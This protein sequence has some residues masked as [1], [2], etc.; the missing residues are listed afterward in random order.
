MSKNHHEA[1]QHPVFHKV[2]QNLYRLESSGGY[3]ALFKRS[4]K[5]I[6]RS[7]KTTDPALARRRLGELHDKVS[8]LNQTKGAS[9]IT[10][11]QLGDRWLANIRVN[12]KESSAERLE[13]CLKGLEP[14]LGHVAVRNVT[15][16]HCEAWM[17][18]RGKQISAS[19]Y[20]HER[21]TLIAVL[22]YAVR[23]GLILN[24]PA[25][26]AVPTR[27]IPKPK[28]TIPTQEQFRLLVTT[29]RQA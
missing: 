19:S 11:K 28:I 26:V 18:K 8:R 23:D 5:Q 2:G 13:I 17:T 24:N 22:D 29:I 12:L 7:L 27:K 9:K 10:F 25:R 3:Y 20:K 4:G 16:R 1:S 15:H 21:R 14:Y 6:R